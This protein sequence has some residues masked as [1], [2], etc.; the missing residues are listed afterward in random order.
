MR[1]LIGAGAVA[2]ALAAGLSLAVTAAASAFMPAPAA[3]TGAAIV[4][5]GGAQTNGLPD[6]QTRARVARGVALWRAGAAP[7]LVMTGGA[8]DEGRPATAALMAALAR[9]A[10]VPMAA[11]RVEDRSHSTLQN[12]LF[13]RPLLP[14]GTV[15]LVS[16]RY[17]LPR[18][19]ASFRWAGIAPLRLVPAEERA[20]D[21]RLWLNDAAPWL[22]ALKW[23]LNVVRAALATAL[24]AAGMAP[25][26]VHPLLA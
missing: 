3:P 10:G 25:G 12:A 13:A 4:V 11:L 8:P 5:L 19:W 7:V 20:A 2:A 14:E 15:I 17:H 16:H 24:Q 26:R 18:A 1:W 22:E 23:P 6:R 21:G 9:I